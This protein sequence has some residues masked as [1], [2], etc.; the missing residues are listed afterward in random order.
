L[1][2]EYVEA[3]NWN[4]PWRGRVERQGNQVLYTNHS[5]VSTL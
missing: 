4:P 1:T 2:G 3:A 5:D